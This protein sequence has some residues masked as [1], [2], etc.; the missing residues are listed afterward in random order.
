MKHEPHR[1]QGK[2]WHVAERF[3]EPGASATDDRRPEFQKLIDLATSADRPLDII[4]V[5]SMSRFFRDQ[6]RSEFYIHKLRKASVE[7]VSLTQP[8]ENDP[9]PPAT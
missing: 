8:F 1:C 6:F 5:H 2:G 7:V 4:L 3:I 9:T